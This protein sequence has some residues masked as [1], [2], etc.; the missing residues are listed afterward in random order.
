MAAP[1]DNG[2]VV[3]RREFHRYAYLHAFKHFFAPANAWLYGNLSPLVEPAWLEA[4]R[5]E[6]V[7]FALHDHPVLRGAAKSVRESIAKDYGVD[8]RAA[9]SPAVRERLRDGIMRLARGDLRIHPQDA[10]AR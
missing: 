2:I 1:H 7:A 10:Q 6:L 5:R 9:I 4:H 8:L 3:L